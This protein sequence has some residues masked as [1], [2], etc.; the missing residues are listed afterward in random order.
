[1][2]TIYAILIG[3]AGGWIIRGLMDLANSK[4][5]KPKA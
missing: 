3:I 1:M 4:Y 5:A 2:K